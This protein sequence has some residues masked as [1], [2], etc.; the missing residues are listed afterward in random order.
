MTIT[1]NDGLRSGGRRPRL[2]LVNGDRAVKFEGKA[3]PGICAIAGERFERNG[4]WSNTTFTISLAAGWKPVELLSRLHGIWGEE[5]PS[6]QELCNQSGLPISLARE[7]VRKEYPKTAARLDE[8]EALSS[9]PQRKIIVSR[10]PAA[11]EFIRQELGQDWAD[12]QVMATA[13]PDDVRDAEVAGNLPLMLASLARVVIA[14]EFEGD[15]PRGQE[16][17][18]E[19][20]RAAGARISRYTVQQVQEAR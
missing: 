8:L 14:V 11:V 19:E 6:W 5:Y 18:I 10:H 1:F 16:Y 12:A 17:G 3:I 2:Y 4:K 13:T 9:P 7:I 15:P 20:M